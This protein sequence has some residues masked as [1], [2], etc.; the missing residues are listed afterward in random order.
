MRCVEVPNHVNSTDRIERVVLTGGAVFL[1]FGR[2]T[3]ARL[4]A[5]LATFRRP[6]RAGAGAARGAPAL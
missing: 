4:S 2:A 3:L 5:G 6:A 1:A